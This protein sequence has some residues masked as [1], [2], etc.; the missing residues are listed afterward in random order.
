MFE[1]RII[2]GYEIVN[3]L[4]NNFK[5]ELSLTDVCAICHNLCCKI[6]GTG[7]TKEELDLIL[8]SGYENYFTKLSPD[9]FHTIVTEDKSC[10]YLKD[11]ECSIYEVRPLGCRLFPIIEVPRQGICLVHCPLTEFLTKSSIQDSL[12]LI[13]SRPRRIAELSLQFLESNH[14][15]SEIKLGSFEIEMRYRF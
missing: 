14:V 2:I 5:T 12:K 4:D 9:L 6:G 10:P 15:K 7:C 3:S 11:A 13:L 8:E 1:M